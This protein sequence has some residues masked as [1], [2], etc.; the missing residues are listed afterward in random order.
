[1]RLYLEN[2]PAVDGVDSNLERR[3]CLLILSVDRFITGLKMLT[4]DP[5]KT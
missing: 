1:M 5:A 2:M 4:I 3:Q